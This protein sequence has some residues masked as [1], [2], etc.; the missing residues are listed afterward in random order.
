M[1]CDAP[2]WSGR[3]VLVTGA[4]GFLGSHLC[5]LL[6]ARGS[7]VHGIVRHRAAPEGVVPHPADLRHPVAWKAA[8][9]KADPEIVFH[10]AAPVDLSRSPSALPRLRAGILD[11]THHVALACLGAGVPLVS[12]CTCEVYGTQPAPFREDC[13]PLPVSAYSSLK[14]AAASW[15]L[16]LAR[17]EGLQ[18]TIVRPFLTY[19]PGHSPRRLVGAA[20]EAARAGRRFALTAGKQTREF[21]FVGDLVRG[22]AA[23]ASPHTR[24][25]VIN[26]GGGPEVEVR[27][28]A[29][30]IFSLAGRDPDLVRE[31]SLPHRKGETLRFYGDHALARELLGHQPRVPLEQG[32]L[33]TLDPH[34]YPL[35]D[36]Y[37]EAP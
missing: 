18:V 35:P 33:H 14:A 2:S 25:R 28:M 10:L 21:N 29:R 7:E 4:G 8:F 9:E 17:Q 23:A 6:L 30:I 5:R 15:L 1:P 32:L 31:G 11:A 16:T 34:G 24:G 26:L 19:G 3:R 20:M 36:L 12:T 27:A 37:G 13:P 22:L